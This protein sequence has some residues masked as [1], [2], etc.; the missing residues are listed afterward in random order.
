MA[1]ADIVEAFKRISSNGS[2]TAALD[3]II[4]ALSPYEWREALNKLQERAFFLDIV[5]SVPSEIV[6]HVFSYLDILTPFRLQRVSRRW[7]VILTSPEILQAL[8]NTW[9]S[10]RDRQL[11]G[12][13]TLKGQ[14][15]AICKLKADHLHRFR[16]GHF[17]SDIHISISDQRPR[18]TG[19]T[20]AGEHPGVDFCDDTV[21]WIDK[22]SGTDMVKVCN[23]R[24]GK[25]IAV[26]GDG[27]ESIQSI[28]LT[29]ELVAIS[30]Y[31]G[32]CYACDLA[33]GEKRSFR[34]PSAN[35]MRWSCRGRSIGGVLRDRR[36]NSLETTA[37]VWEY[38]SRRCKTF[39]I[40]NP[41]AT[42]EKKSFGSLSDEYLPARAVLINPSSQTILV[43]WSANTETLTIIHFCR[44]TY[45]GEKIGKDSTYSLECCAFP[46][47]FSAVD[48]CGG[49]RLCLRTVNE[50]W[51]G[52]SSLA[53]TEQSNK[54]EDR[55][56]DSMLNLRETSWKDTTYRI[57]KKTGGLQV[58]CC[59]TRE[60]PLR[61]PLAFF[62]SRVGWS[63]QELGA[64]LLLNDIFVVL[65]GPDYLHIWCFDKDINLPKD[66]LK[67]LHKQN[68]VSIA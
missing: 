34:L 63:Q 1:A 17:Y 13:S 65:F 9:Y 49:F 54:F 30:T 67:A 45:A 62:K 68:R 5:A 43:C 31:S 46:L 29:D 53:F 55:E 61:S 50:D 12:E 26:A 18:R 28:T 33:T 47:K 3:G 16:S 35:D 15:Y 20:A 37:F 40:Q 48:R 7:Q 38:H 52:M 11:E 41:R 22:V 24:T 57:Y 66:E 21:A 23:L 10:K 6:I 2:R 58:L 36:N 44:Y 25:C 4:A 42:S 14:E 27:R 51:Q 60:A 56:G 64:F 8:L 39:Q 32:P 59:G 19:H